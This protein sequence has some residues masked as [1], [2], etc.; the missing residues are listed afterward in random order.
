VLTVGEPT[1]GDATLT[2]RQREEL[3]VFDHFVWSVVVVPLAVPAA[4]YLLAD[5]LRPELAA[6]VFAWS[7]VAAGV[8]AAVTLLAFALKAAAEVPAIARAGG[9]SP[10]PL[11]ADTRHVV[12][13]L[14]LLWCVAAAAAVAVAWRRYRRALT[15]ADRYARDLP[16]DGQ[17]VVVPGAGVDAFA[18]PGRPGRIVVTAGMRDALDAGMYDALIA[19]ERCHLDERHDRLVWLARLGAAI[20]P[21]LT[22]M[23]RQVEYLVERAADEAAADVLGSRRQV[24]SAIGAAALQVTRTDHRPGALHVGSPGRTVVRRVT[25]LLGVRLSARGLLVI[26]ILLATST[27]VWAGECVYDLHELIAGT[28]F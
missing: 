17:V 9:W 2:A 25:A 10:G 8:A 15:S 22:P 27:F 1:G 11:T 23:V 18:L 7:T 13:W 28:A 4:A 21:V 19:H 26:P 5:R 14:S 20:H 16:G 6:R 24:A 3:A 12:S